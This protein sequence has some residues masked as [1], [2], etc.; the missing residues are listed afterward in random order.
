VSSVRDTKGILRKEEKGFTER[1]STMGER[2]I[3]IKSF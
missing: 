1:G 3:F 2:R